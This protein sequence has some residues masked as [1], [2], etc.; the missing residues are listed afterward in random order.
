M[1]KF[2]WSPSPN[3]PEKPASFAGVDREEMVRRARD[4]APRLRQRVG[5][6]ERLRRMPDDT[7]RDL[8]ELGLFRIA[9]PARVGGADLDVGIFV[10]VCAEI[11][12]VCPSTAWNLGNLAAHQDARLLPARSPG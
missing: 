1:A 5:L 7:E 8:H 6:C 12:K 3:L 2:E 10:D 9:Q 4:L 11:V